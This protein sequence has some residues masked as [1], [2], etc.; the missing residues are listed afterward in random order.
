MKFGWNL[1]ETRGWRMDVKRARGHSGKSLPPTLED[2]QRFAS[3]AQF[4][5]LSH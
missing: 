3:R 2:A 4:W 1:L 5:V